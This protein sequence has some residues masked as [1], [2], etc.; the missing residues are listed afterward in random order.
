MGGGGSP[1]SLTRFPL[2]SWLSED[3]MDQIAVVLDTSLKANNKTDTTILPYSALH[4]IV[5]IHRTTT[6]RDV[7]STLRKIPHVTTPGKRIADGSL[8]VLCVSVAVCLGGQLTLP[9]ADC[10]A[11]HW[12]SLVIQ[13]EP[14]SLYFADP[15]GHAAPQ[16]LI[17]VFIWWLGHY[18]SGTFTVRSLPCSSQA[19]GDGDSC[20]LLSANALRH[21]CYPDT[22]LMDPKK[23]NEARVDAFV[24]VVRL[25]QERVCL[26]F[27]QS[28]RILIEIL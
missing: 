21:F 8:R 24:S 2:H 26:P 12:V 16:E 20:G 9:S 4:K 5:S 10:Q 13:T 23:P 25:I 22:Q 18:H 15:M 7:Y 27:Y 28:T 6:D 1:L 14:P 19:P 11:N 3:N 17:D